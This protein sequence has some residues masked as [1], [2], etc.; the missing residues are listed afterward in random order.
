MATLCVWYT[1]GLSRSRIARL[2]RMTGML[3]QHFK[4]RNAHSFPGMWF[5]S[6]SLS[7][8]SRQNFK[9]V[10]CTRLWRIVVRQKFRRNRLPLS[11][12][13]DKPSSRE[14]IALLGL[15]F[16][17]E[18]IG[19]TFFRNLKIN[20]V[21]TTRRHIRNDSSSSNIPTKKLKFTHLINK[22][23][24]TKFRI[25]RKNSTATLAHCFDSRG[26]RIYW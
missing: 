5:L 14:N 1:T 10:C 8:S 4:C 11:S 13:S 25:A 16:D 2:V 22:K 6:L 19:N 24:E 12:R 3:G 20:F 7:T 17:P 23:R 18:G 26:Y 15:L 9:R 21:E